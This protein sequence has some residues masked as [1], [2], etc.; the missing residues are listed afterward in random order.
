MKQAR[1]QKTRKC[2]NNVSSNT[3]TES[4]AIQY[5]ST[6]NTAQRIVTGKYLKRRHRHGTNEG[7]SYCSVLDQ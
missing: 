5:S 7:R 1:K 3:T 2:I 6:H 4:N